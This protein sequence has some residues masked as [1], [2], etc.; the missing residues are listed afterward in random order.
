MTE[1]F[2]G[3]KWYTALL[4]K[5]TSEAHSY[6]FHLAFFQSRLVSCLDRYP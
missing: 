2:T 3:L 6:D 4:N 1:I 5:F